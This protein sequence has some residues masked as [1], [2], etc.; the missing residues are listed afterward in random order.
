MIDAGIGG[1]WFNELGSRMDLVPVDGGRLT[2]TYLLAA[3]MTGVP[4]EPHPLAGFFDAYPG[5]STAAVSFTVA[6]PSS[7]SITA[8]LGRHDPQDEVITTTWLFTGEMGIESGWR[9][10]MVGSDVFRRA[11]LT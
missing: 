11:A 5:R 10:T 3:T 9:A 8:W 7:H 4:A 1:T 2:G 6:W